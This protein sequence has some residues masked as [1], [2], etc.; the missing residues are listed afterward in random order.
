M[1]GIATIS[2]MK[3]M[4]FDVYALQSASILSSLL[5]ISFR[6]IVQSTKHAPAFNYSSDKYR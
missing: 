4:R 1:C 5:V 2:S 3:Y 6:S